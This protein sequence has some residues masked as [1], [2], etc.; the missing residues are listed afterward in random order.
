MECVTFLSYRSVLW[1]D[2]SFPKFKSN[3]RSSRPKFLTERKKAKKKRRTFKIF[4]I[5]YNKYKNTILKLKII[6]SKSER[7]SP[8]HVLRIIHI[9]TP[10]LAAW[11]LRD[12]TALKSILWKA[13][14]LDQLHDFSLLSSN[15]FLQL[16]LKSKFMKPYRHR[17]SDPDSVGIK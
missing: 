1:L 7:S 14:F 17:I 15:S 12:H 2:S 4:L 10:R 5:D 9:L 13:L 8:S 3:L 16:F 11:P 6:I